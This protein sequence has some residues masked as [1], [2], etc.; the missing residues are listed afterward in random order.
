MPNKFGL[1]IWLA[2]DIQNKYLFN[3][4]LYTGKDET[5]SL[6][7]SVPKDV[8]WKLMTTLFQREYN[9]IYDNFFTSLDLALRLE[10]NKCSLAGT[11]R[12]NRREIPHEYKVEGQKTVA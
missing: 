7:V 12:Q 1:K 4:F 10:D 5:R 9:V 8:V 11:T 6:N 2:L 3:G